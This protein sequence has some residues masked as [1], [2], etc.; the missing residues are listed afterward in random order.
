MAK[1]YEI[2]IDGLNP[3]K[4]YLNRL[5]G[6]FESKQLMA[7][8]GM[9]LVGAIKL[10]TADGEDVEGNK[11]KPYSPSYALFRKKKGLQTDEVDLFFTGSMMS[12]MTYD[13]SDTK[14]KVYFL[15]TESKGVDGGEGAKNPDKAAWLNEKREFF[16][17]SDDDIEEIDEIVDD[18]ITRELGL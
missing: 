9:F 11:F 6:G 4:N 10:R 1:N 18:F 16:A 7:E 15:N 3:L 5:S 14:V 8:I 13:A 2:T 12:S 17:M